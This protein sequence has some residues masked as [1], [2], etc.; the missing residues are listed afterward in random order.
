MS[1]PLAPLPSPA[2]A[3]APTLR[4]VPTG[5][6]PEPAAGAAEEQRWLVALG[7]PFV[8][9]A[10]FFALSIALSAEWPIGSIRTTTFWEHPIICKRTSK[11][12]AP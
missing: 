5:A 3:N 8:L 9:G 7:T 4:V 1:A 10:L 11:D 6:P 12:T 2:P